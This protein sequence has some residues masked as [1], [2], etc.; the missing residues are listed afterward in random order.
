MPLP[1]AAWRPTLA[2]WCSSFVN[3]CISKS[4]LVGTNSKLA[5][6]W[7]EWGVDSERRPGSIVVVERGSPPQGHVGFFVGMDDGRIR[8]LGGNQGDQV[9]IAQLRSPPCVVA[10]RW[11]AAA[12]LAEPT[13]GEG[14]LAG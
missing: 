13:G 2:P 8:L 14:F 9:G 4:G 5:R 10:V 12:A 3:Y 7:A 6:S 1:P 11:P